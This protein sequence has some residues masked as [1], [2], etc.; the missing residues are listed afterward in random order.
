MLQALALQVGSEVSF[1][2]LAGLLSIDSATVR[3]YLTY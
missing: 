2:E 1:N 3:R